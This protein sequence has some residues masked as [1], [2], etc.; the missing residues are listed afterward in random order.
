MTYL[1]KPKFHHPDLPKNELDQKL[2]FMLTEREVIDW[3][4]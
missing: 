4:K 2:D 3:S 1:A